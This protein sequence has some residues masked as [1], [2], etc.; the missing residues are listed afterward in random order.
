MVRLRILSLSILIAGL[1]LAAGP[2][3]VAKAQEAPRRGAPPARACESNP[4]PAFTT[5]F[6]DLTMIS[7]MLP[8]AV[9]SGERFKNRSYISI[10]RDAEGGF[11]EVPIYAP[12]DSTLVSITYFTQP[13]TDEN[14]RQILMELYVLEFQVSCEVT[15]GFDHVDR[16]VGAAADAA[17]AEPAP[18]TRNAAVYVNVPFKAGELIGYTRGTPRARNWDFIVTNRGQANVF[19][20]PDRYAAQGDLRS[21]LTG[22]CGYDYFPP[23]IRSQ[24]YALLHGLTEDAESCFGMPDEPG[25]IAGG[26]FSQKFG[27]RDPGEFDPGWA[28]AIGTAYDQI[29]I[30]TAEASIR[31]N[32]GAAT[33]L[34]PRTVTTEH[35]YQSSKSRDYA[36]V[37][38]VAPLE[39]ALALGQ[40]GCP[41]RLPSN[42]QT[43]YR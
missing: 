2:A 22:A 1:F 17:P 29:R 9:I 39:L 26:W 25:A 34:N 27:V 15:Y 14:D 43:Y 21:L 36:F 37:K 40:G 23:A 16:L 3:L 4:S 31:I 33:Y 35:C 8:P 7:A 30:N 6:T 18:D 20:N 19:A 41:D 5:P 32:P 12:A 10:G 38:L 24:F 13:A 28:V 42:F 11:F